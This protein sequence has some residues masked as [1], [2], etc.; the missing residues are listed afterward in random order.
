MI[1][2]ESDS[3]IER[4]SGR[5]RKYGELEG[6]G[7]H[8]DHSI[9]VRAPVFVIALVDRTMAE[10]SRMRGHRNESA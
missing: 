1:G 7:I 3:L 2:F 6:G 10:S 5:E 8:F 4:T 9:A